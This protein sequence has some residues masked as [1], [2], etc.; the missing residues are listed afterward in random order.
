MSVTDYVPGF[1]SMPESLSVRSRW[2]FSW[3]S[4]GLLAPVI[5][6]V[7]AMY[8]SM[9]G[10]PDVNLEAQ[11][12]AI[13][14]SPTAPVGQGRSVRWVCVAVPET[15]ELQPQDPWQLE[16]VQAGELFDV[17]GATR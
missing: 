13:S 7:Y 10:S 11:D 16:T 3:L 17:P 2:I 14:E 9:S 8:G 5:T 6:G 1:Q 15:Q 4:I 12:R